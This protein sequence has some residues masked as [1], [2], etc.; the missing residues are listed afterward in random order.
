MKIKTTPIRT[1][2]MSYLETGKGDPLIL[3]H[4][5]SVT[6]FM[7]EDILE[8]LSTNF[9]VY[10]PFLRG[11]VVFE[12]RIENISLFMESLGVKKAVL[13]GHSSSG[14]DAVLF[15]R[16]FTDKTRA[17]ILID[18]LGFPLHRSMRKWLAVWLNHVVSFSVGRKHQAFSFTQKLTANFLGQVIHYPR[19]LFQEI[20][21]ALAIDITNDWKKI[22]IPSL[23]IWGK[24]DIL[25]PVSVAEKMSEMNK[26]AM[27]QMVEG[28]HNW[29]KVK[30]TEFAENVVL[31]LKRVESREKSSE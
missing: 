23:L 21:N 14:I 31:F 2:S 26:Q 10:A 7:Y 4:G 19:V 25:V 8:A 16:H 20:Q 24:D 5:W 27:F 15:A 6:P 13:V 9:H 18:T 11:E 17:L 28:D 29:V 30:P 12:K 3:L 1:Q 22:N